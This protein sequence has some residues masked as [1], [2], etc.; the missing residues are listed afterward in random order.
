MATI[1]R[2]VYNFRSSTEYPSSISGLSYHTALSTTDRQIKDGDIIELQEPISNLYVRIEQNISRVYPRY[3]Y[4]HLRPV[5]RYPLTIPYAYEIDIDPFLTYANGNPAVARS[6]FSGEMFVEQST[7]DIPDI[8]L[9]PESQEYEAEMTMNY[10]GKFSFALIRTE[11]DGASGVRERH[12]YITEDGVNSSGVPG[13]IDLIRGAARNGNLYASDGTTQVAQKLE[14][15]DVYMIP[16]EFM[17]GVTGAYGSTYYLQAPN[18]G[19]IKEVYRA[20][21]ST[22]FHSRPVIAGGWCTIGNNT[23]Q[24]QFPVG[25]NQS[26]INYQLRLYLDGSA[27]NLSI[28][29]YVKKSGSGYLEMGN[30]FR[31]AMNIPA[32]SEVAQLQKLRET[33][34]D[35]AK[36]GGSVITLGAGIFTGNPTGILGGAASTAQ[37]I[38]DV[39][40]KQSNQP[41]GNSIAGDWSQNIQAPDGSMTNG[42]WIGI[43]EITTGSSFNYN[44][45]GHRNSTHLFSFDDSLFNATGRL[46]LRGDYRPQYSTN[47]YYLD[48]YLQQKCRRLLA[49]G[50]HFVKTS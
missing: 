7:I 25:M 34:G 14:I 48:S 26:E 47:P 50:V 1:I 24:L 30:S 27:D 5:D 38:F 2:P 15:L 41:K 13:L 33:V 10:K 20:I 6:W 4:A 11:S 44:F 8:P 43:N 19:E 9:L 17:S 18:F 36:I 31:Y 46:Y 32:N 23:A 21:P 39:A 35:V 28:G 40:T 37:S 29:I 42:Y 16:N 22:N 45:Y 12:W 49:E 3:I